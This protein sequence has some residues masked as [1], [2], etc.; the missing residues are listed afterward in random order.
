M[1]DPCPKVR[2][3]VW[4]RA[5][6]ERA[7]IA[8]VALAATACR[9]PEPATEQTDVDEA[10]QRA[11]TQRLQAAREETFAA[12]IE[13]GADAFRLASPLDDAIV[14]D[15]PL[16]VPSRSLDRLADTRAK[17]GRARAEAA[18]LD[19]HDFASTERVMLRTLRFGLD[20]L[21]DRLD[22]HP[23]AR[24]DPNYAVEVLSETLDELERRM[25]LGREVDADELLAEFATAVELWQRELVAANATTT[26]QASARVASLRARLARLGAAS[27]ILDQAGA[28][29]G[30]ESVSKAQAALVGLEQHLTELAAALPGRPPAKPRVPVLVGMEDPPRM[31]ARLGAEAFERRLAVEERLLDGAPVLIAGVERNL[32]RLDAMSK[33]LGPAE[34]S[35]TAA[36]PSAERCDR[37]LARLE[38]LLAEVSARLGADASDVEL[39]RPHCAAWATLHAEQRLDDASVELM[40]LRQF[41][42]VPARR[43]TRREQHPVVALVAGDMAPWAQLHARGIALAMAGGATTVPLARRALDEARDGLCLAGAFVLI[44]AWDDQQLAQAL[45]GTSQATASSIEQ[46]D[47]RADAWLEQWCPQAPVASWRSAALADPRAAARGLGFATFD[48]RPDVM[49]G[50]DHFWWAPLGLTY[51][52]SHPDAPDG[53]PPP[54][55]SAAGERPPLRVKLEIP[56][57]G[58]GGADGPDEP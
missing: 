40:L 3:R 41:V 33:D 38:T 55:G 16:V 35:T 27:V 20:R 13:A 56:G 31:P 25:V 2:R 14:R 47:A 48:D 53:L 5:R 54:V 23:P 15:G 8:L 7:G 26:D 11:E 37:A 42:I 30:A 21:E 9:R 34:P 43:A 18:D 46:A 58:T 36:P 12:A 4:V 52:L 29:V 10:A 17:L 57:S 6:R 44:H 19:E 45:S 1:A 49:A 50:L 39:Q 32:D 22:A 51:M 28:R 24:T